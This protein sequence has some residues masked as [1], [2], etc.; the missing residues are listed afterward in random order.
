MTLN[1]YNKNKEEE[2][3]EE[4]DQ[5]IATKNYQKYIIK[6]NNVTTDLCR[7][8]HQFQETIN[9]VEGGYKILAGMDY[10]DKYNTAAKII[11]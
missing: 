3:E 7:K 2:E 10:K 5:V 6:D 9:H 11:H 1:N 8:C 4:E